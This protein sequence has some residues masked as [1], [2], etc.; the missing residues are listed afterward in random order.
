MNGIRLRNIGRAYDLFSRIAD[1]AKR[2]RGKIKLIPYTGALKM[3]DVAV[4]DVAYPGFGKKLGARS[5]HALNGSR[6][7]LWYKAAHKPTA[8]QIAKAEYATKTLRIPRQRY[9]GTLV[10]VFR[11]KGTLYTLLAGVLERD[12]EAGKHAVNFRMMNL[13]D[14]TLYAAY[15]EEQTLAQAKSMAKTV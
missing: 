14:G 2:R 3:R 12:R 13:D 5:K 8:S 4:D 9:T 6:V 1:H 7:T 11:H 15:L 10:D